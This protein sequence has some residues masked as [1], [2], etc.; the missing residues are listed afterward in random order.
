MIW[1]K[2]LTAWAED[3]VCSNRRNILSCVEK[4]EQEDIKKGVA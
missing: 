3:V 4:P 2:Q 1:N